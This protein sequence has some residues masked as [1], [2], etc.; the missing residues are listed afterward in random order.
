MIFTLITWLQAKA[1]TNERGAGMSEY[2]LL[3]VLVGI[4]VAAALPTLTGAISNA[5]TQVA[6]EITTAN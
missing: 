4:V 5:F 2:A 3:L 1:V 6:N